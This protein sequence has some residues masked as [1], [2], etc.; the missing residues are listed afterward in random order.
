MREHIHLQPHQLHLPL[1]PEAEAEVLAACRQFQRVAVRAAQ[2]KRQ[3]MAR[4]FDYLKG[5]FHEGD[6]LPLPA[7]AGSNEDLNADRPKAFLPMVK[8]IVN[9]LY[10][11]LK[12]TFF[13]ND[14]DY[15][16]VRGRDS[17]AAL[18]EEDL[19]DALKQVF[20]E[21]V[22]T[23]QMGEFLYNLCWSGVGAVMPTIEE[24][25]RWEWTLDA[26]AGEYVQTPL[27]LTPRPKLQVL[28]PLRFYV[29]PT[30]KDTNAQDTGWCYLGR[31]KVREL[32]DSGMARHQ[33]Q[34]LRLLDEP[35]GIGGGADP[36]NGA[37]NTEGYLDLLEQVAGH[38]PT[39]RYDLY[40]FPFLKTQDTIY[41]NMIVGVVAD[42]WVVRFH[43]NVYP[44]GL[45]PV[46]FCTWRPDPESPYGEGPAEEVLELQRLA[47][48]LENYKLE[49]MARIGNRFVVPEGTDMSQ[50]FGLAGGVMITD[51]PSEVRSF[52]GDYAEVAALTNQVG[53]LKAE[54]QI[55]SG[56]QNPFQ[57]ASNVDFKKTATELQILQ[58]QTVTVLRE[59]IEHLGL[60]GIKQIL[61]R[62]MVLVAMSHPD[63]VTIRKDDPAQGVQFKTVPLDALLSGRYYIDVVSINLGQSRK[64]QI[65]QLTQLL[66]IAQ[67][68]QTLRPYLKAGGY[69]ILKK[70]A[71]LSGLKDVDTFL[72]S[73]FELMQELAQLQRPDPPPSNGVA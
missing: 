25:A 24:Q 34:L 38:E 50:F 15:F 63:P 69:P 10:A 6:L 48:I 18:L 33:D 2:G 52:T 28:H 73:P 32:L 61:E 40:Y 57:G 5:N 17:E 51:R 30:V 36:G 39:V 13:P 53:I 7:V 8:Q 22:L 64:A 62:L 47:N 37:L 71:V 43:P 72:K 54:A 67:Q 26:M 29:D 14:E 58:E 9:T 12:L 68:E 55:T 21:A 27:S 42:Q 23:E 65:D 35:G 41:R 44:K 46:V 31:K 3:K 60:T 1:S 49:V 66:M 19:T 70:I 20:K 56:A 16:R 45:N 11:Q 4:A 59:V